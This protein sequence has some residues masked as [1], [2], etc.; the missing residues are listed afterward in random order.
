MDGAIARERVDRVAIEQA[1]RCFDSLRRLASHQLN[2]S[3]LNASGGIE[4]RKGR[5]IAEGMEPGAPRPD[6]IFF[7]L[8]PS[9][10]GKGNSPQPHPKSSSNDS[11]TFPAVYPTLAYPPAPLFLASLLLPSS[12]LSPRPLFESVLGTLRRRIPLEDKAPAGLAPACW[13]CRRYEA[14]SFF[15]LQIPPPFAPFSRPVHQMD[16]CPRG[17]IERNE[18][19]EY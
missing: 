6:D 4:R 18:H 11:R 13:R 10:G 5:R 15:G 7:G 14:M 12:C 16:K 2:R 17:R 8:R 3:A 1:Q 19:E 9:D